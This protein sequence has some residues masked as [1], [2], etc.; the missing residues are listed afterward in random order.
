MSDS[1]GWDESSSEEEWGHRGHASNTWAGES[2]ESPVDDIFTQ[3]SNYHSSE[4]EY[5]E[6]Y[7]TE[8]NAG[9]GRITQEEAA[10]IARTSGWEENRLQNASS[11]DADLFCIICL[12]VCR[13]A[14]QCPMQHHACEA[15]IHRWLEESHS[16]P[17]CQMRLTTDLLQPA[18]FVRKMVDKQVIKCRFRDNGCE[19]TMRIEI[20]AAHERQCGF[21][22]VGCAN[23][24][25][26]EQMLANNLEAHAVTCGFAAV[27]CPRCGADLMRRDLQRHMDDADCFQVLRDISRRN[28]EEKQALEREVE[29][30]T[31]LSQTLLES[32][33]VLTEQFKRYQ[34][35]RQ[36][37][38]PAKGLKKELGNLRR[39]T[40]AQQQQLE[41]QKRLLEDQKHQQARQR[42]KLKFL[43]DRLHNPEA[44][45]VSGH[46]AQVCSIAT[47]DNLLFTGSR[48]ST[49]RVWDMD[50][51]F[52]LVDIL[53]HHDNSVFVLL[54]SGQL[55]VSGSYDKTI[56]VWSIT[57][58]RLTGTR[59]KCGGPVRALAIYNPP[60]L[61]VYL[62][63]GDG[64]GMIQCWDATSGQTY[65]ALHDPRAH[66]LGELGSVT[67]LALSGSVLASAHRSG[68]IAL[69]NVETDTQI[70]RRHSGSAQVWGLALRNDILVYG[71][72]DG[73]I[74]VW[75]LPDD[76]FS[77]EPTPRRKLQGNSGAISQ[78]SFVEHSSQVVSTS[79]D[80]S[81]EVWCVETGDHLA[82]IECPGKRPMCFALTEDYLICGTCDQGAK[83]VDKPSDVVVWTAALV[84]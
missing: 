21:R 10:Q 4:A 55:L 84:L 36:R 65:D 80:G 44:N 58:N 5:V 67:K 8:V 28:S 82:S 71:G 29:H 73:T 62:Y 59:F 26:S 33:S 64:H 32:L 16:C 83:K 23:A 37:P 7:D 40:E 9:S 39:L 74:S 66:D 52:A 30:L 54:V 34:L 3:S 68:C 53:Q 2:E 13:D 81:V 47:S 27:G 42:R 12:S 31:G 70:F 45:L 48:D 50:Y 1:G 20:V 60:G 11:A 78:V 57:K 49:I 17:S 61:P 69:W 75:D 14:V 18:L 22:M 24:G 51:N 38:D 63:S 46:E 19:E 41:E 76:E 43:Q 35:E 77:A 15:C 79:S 72:N 25:C 56:Q 6:P